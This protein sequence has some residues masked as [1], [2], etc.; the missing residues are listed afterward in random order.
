MV[1]EDRLNAAAGT[2]GGEGSSLGFAGSHEAR[3]SE[4]PTTRAPE[5]S[6]ARKRIEPFGGTGTPP[7]RCRHR[8]SATLATATEVYQY[9]DLQR[10]LAESRSYTNLTPTGALSE[11]YSYD[12]TGNILSKSDFG[13]SYVYGNQALRPHGAGPHA[14]LSVAAPAG[15]SYTYDAN[16]NMLSDGQRNVTYD[17]EDRPE[18]ITMNGVATVFRYTPDGDRYLQRTTS[19]ADTSINRTIYYVEKDYERVDWDQKPNEERTYCGKGVVIEQKD[20]SAREARYLHLDRLGSTTAVS[21]ANGGEIPDDAHGFDAFGRPRGRDWQPT[22]DQMHPKG[23]WGTT[24]NH[25][26]TGHEQLD[27]TYLTHMNGRVYDYRLGR[28]LSV[29]PL[30]STPTNSQS[31]NPYS[32]IGNNPLS[33]TD[34]SGYCSV[35]TGGRM[36]GIDKGGGDGG[37][38]YMGGSGPLDNAYDKSGTLL[39]Q[40]IHGADAQRVSNSPFAAQTPAIAAAYGAYVI[41]NGALTN[42]NGRQNSTNPGDVGTPAATASQEA[43]EDGGQGPTKLPSMEE[44]EALR[45]AIKDAAIKAGDTS[46]RQF[47]TLNV[48]VYGG[49]AKERADIL[50]AAGDVFTKSEHGGWGLKALESR[51]TWFGFGSTK[52]FDIIVG[53][54]PVGSFTLGGSQEMLLDPRQVNNAAYSSLFADPNSG[55]FTYQRIIAHELGHAAMGTHDDGAGRM[56]NVIRNENVIMRQLGDYNDRIEF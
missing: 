11:S 47:G 17:D 4:R 48:N 19:S 29:D 9:D 41:T 3:R 31:I 53:R 15:W 56:N 44:L 37:P 1:I 24:T 27:E 54:S 35:V 46:T 45:Q 5:L 50:A 52:P 12:D 25:G 42:Q 38:F 28:F 10:L 6:A 7:S 8:S 40:Y 51:K 23:E 32:Y 18:T 2:E 16:G 33:G 43:G 22:S 30:I 39:G 26:F 14:V 34:P 13:S 55:R 21:D 20:G 36:F 49:T